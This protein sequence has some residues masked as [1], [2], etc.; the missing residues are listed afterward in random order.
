M[1]AAV[2]S[3]YSV[4]ARCLARTLFTHQHSGDDGAG[5]RVKKAPERGALVLGSNNPLMLRS[6]TGGLLPGCLAGGMGMSG[7]AASGLSGPSA[8]GIGGGGH[9][10]RPYCTPASGGGRSLGTTDDKDDNTPS[11]K[12]ILKSMLVYLWPSGNPALQVR[13]IPFLSFF[14]PSSL[15][16]LLLLYLH[17]SR[18]RPSVCDAPVSLNLHCVSTCFDNLAVSFC[19]L[20]FFSP[21][22]CLILSLPQCLLFPFTNPLPFRFF[23]T[24]SC[25]QFRS[26]RAASWVIALPTSLSLFFFLPPFFFFF[27]S[28]A[29][30]LSP[31]LSLSLSFPSLWFASPFHFVLGTCCWCT[32]FASNGKSG[33]RASTVLL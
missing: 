6:Q 22:L 7:A 30:T 5:Y 29:H 26:V 32:Q 24:R 11:D 20:V 33:Q 2:R 28:P 21:L 19:V 17:C 15:S 27:F 10:S 8:A 16:L 23:R 25:V 4:G 1:A 18:S 31:S 9:R 12:S 13:S 3:H 14:F